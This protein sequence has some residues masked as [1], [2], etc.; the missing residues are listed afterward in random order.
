LLDDVSSYIYIPSTKAFS[1][2]YLSI[3]HLL[4]KLPVYGS[5]TLVIDV[6]WSVTDLPSFTVSH[7][8]AN[9]SSVSAHLLSSGAMRTPDV[10]N[11]FLKNMFQKW[12]LAHSVLVK[13]IH[14]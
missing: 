12:L 10:D 2:F 9:L 5:C 1:C 8:I 7:F 4:L 6:K 11:R 3:F 14:I 13:F